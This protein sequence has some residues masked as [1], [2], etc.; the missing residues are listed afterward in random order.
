MANAREIKLGFILH[1]IGRT[2]N[3]WRHSGKDVN[4][5]TS[6]AL[7][8]HQA[9]TAERG[10]FDFLF[11]T[12]SLSVTEKSSTHYLNRFEPITILSA[13]AGVTSCIGLVATLTKRATST[14]V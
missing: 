13:L 7:Y 14:R 8:R 5:S 4:A 9:Q 10:K 11:V 3:D 1:G 6:F 12:D 2:W